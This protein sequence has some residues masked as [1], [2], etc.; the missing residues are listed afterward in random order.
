MSLF[1]A[2][3]LLAG[4]Q[5]WAQ[6]P[7]WQ[8]AMAA[9]QTAIS[10]SKVFESAT[11]AN[12]NLFLTGPFR[13]TVTFGNT[14]LV[15]A[16]NNEDIFVAKWSPVTR[17]FVWAQR[18]GGVDIDEV[19]SVAVS[20]TNVY[21]VGS[22]YTGSASFGST[23]IPSNGIYGTGFVAKLNDNG[24]TGRFEWA[25]ALGGPAA[26]V[27]ANGANVY[28]TGI[29]VGT[30]SF[31]STALTSAGKRDLYLAKL[32][33]AGTNSSIDW[34]LRAGGSEDDSGICVAVSGSSVYIAGGFQ[35]PSINFGSTVL[36]QAGS[37][38]A[39]VAKAIDA[40][41]TA[42]FAWALK[43]GG[44]GADEAHVLDVSGNNLYVAGHVGDGVATFG[45]AVLP[46]AAAVTTSGTKCTSFVARLNDAGASASFVWAQQVGGAGYNTCWGVKARGTNV[47]LVG[48]FV[49]TSI[50]GSTSISTAAGSPAL[51]LDMF[52]TRL[53]DAG[54]SASFDWALQGG[55]PSTENG[56]A[57]SVSGTQVYVSGATSAPST[58][59]SHAISS[60]SWLAVAAIASLTDV[61]ITATATGLNK[62]VGL[63]P[64]P[65]HGRATVQLPAAT[66][67]ATLTILDALG[68]TLRTQ[69]V[70]A[71]SKA[72]L[73]LTGLAPGLY[74]LRIAAG[75][76]TATRRLMVE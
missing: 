9:T 38:D 53:S 57:L 45:N 41:S 60:T 34:T 20:G 75:A 52:V 74:A 36:A 68:R 66:G 42:S 25:Q 22:F 43:A 4:Q 5:S 48:E 12:G 63:F 40:G 72:D 28:V 8:L 76:D 56:Y 16:G 1:I 31:G 55:G 46:G 39:F 35:S 29:F 47:Y 18:A 62:N 33:D 49:N 27:A 24:T 6:V 61:S 11:D 73:D 14:T 30:A 23:V 37:G 19:Y 44:S 70:P 15:S 69:T 21:I 26:W 71:N 51:A 32:T 59:G 50:F 13:G 3:A 17:G 2:L 64:D 65:A 10:S 67:T 58:F 54:N 7:A